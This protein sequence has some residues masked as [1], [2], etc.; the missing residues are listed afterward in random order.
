M[1]AR[2]FDLRYRSGAFHV[3]SGTQRDVSGLDL[4]ALQRLAFEQTAAHQTM[5]CWAAKVNINCFFS[6]P[7][8][9][10]PIDIHSCTKSVAASAR[11]Y[12]GQ[13]KI[14]CGYRI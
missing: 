10:S 5:F 1:L 6:I 14:R 9:N 8:F 11:S 3:G 7:F 2:S 13:R 4:R 12:R